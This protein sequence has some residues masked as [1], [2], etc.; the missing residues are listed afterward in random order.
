MSARHQGQ[1]PH[2]CGWTAIGESA[3]WL[4][5]GWRSAARRGRRGFDKRNASNFLS[6]TC[7]F[8]RHGFLCNPSYSYFHLAGGISICLFV[9]FNGLLV[10]CQ[11]Q[12]CL[13]TIPAVSLV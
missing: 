1:G 7:H 6:V 5:I 8:I 13:L 9:C 4:R 10:L 3:A 12:T 2:S 11:Y